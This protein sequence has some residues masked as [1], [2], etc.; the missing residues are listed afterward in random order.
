MSFDKT[1]R[2]PWPALL[3]LRLLLFCAL[4]AL[5]AA[6]SAWAQ[7][8]F[9]LFGRSLFVDTGGITN[10]RC[11]EF[12]SFKVYEEYRL[13]SESPPMLREYGELLVYKPCL[14]PI[15]PLER[16]DFAVEIV[17][18]INCLTKCPDSPCGCEIGLSKAP[19]SL[20]RFPDGIAPA[21]RL[22]GGGVLLPAAIFPPARAISYQLMLRTLGLEGAD[23]SDAEILARYPQYVQIYAPPFRFPRDR[24][25]KYLFLLGVRRDSPLG[26]EVDLIVDPLS[27]IADCAQLRKLIDSPRI[28]AGGQ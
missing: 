2:M 10:F 28:L 11:G 14:Q 23:P 8:D 21:P 13:N 27:E 19:F 25:T 15:Q 6:R 18:A 26:G 5:A 7:D 17:Q 4:L 24:K 16:G 3:A 12:Y 20:V 22:L 9:D 1:V